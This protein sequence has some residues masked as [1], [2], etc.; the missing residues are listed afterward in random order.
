MQVPPNKKS[1]ALRHGSFPNPRGIVGIPVGII[2]RK[3]IRDDILR[4]IQLQQ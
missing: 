1:M 4:L 3:V 2:S